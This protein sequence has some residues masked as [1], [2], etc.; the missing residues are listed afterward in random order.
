MKFW[1]ISEGGEGGDHFR[2]K[3]NSL[4]FFV[5]CVGDDADYGDGNDN[6]DSGDDDE[7]MGE[8]VPNLGWQVFSLH[9]C[10]ERIQ[11]Y[12][13]NS[14][15]ESG[16]VQDI[17]RSKKCQLQV[18]WTPLDPHRPPKKPCDAPKPPQ[19][20]LVTLPTI[21]VIPLVTL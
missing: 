20:P 10:P 17:Q 6:T 5:H 15:T 7:E 2:S 18:E 1:E 14:K 19:N 12:T 11:C 4:Q 21:N 3:Q 16:T 13:K 9:M 8:S